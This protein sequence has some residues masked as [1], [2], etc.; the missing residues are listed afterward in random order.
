MKDMLLNEKATRQFLLSCMS[1]R[2]EVTQGAVDFR[3]IQKEFVLGLN[4]L[5][6]RTCRRAVNGHRS[7]TKTLSELPL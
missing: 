6:K 1:H 3:R 7:S 2:K 4:E 5:F